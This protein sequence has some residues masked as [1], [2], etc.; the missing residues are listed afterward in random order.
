M[1]ETCPPHP[2]EFRR[3]MVDPVRAGRD[4]T[5]LACECE[6][7]GKTIRNRVAEVD[8]S[9]GRREEKLAAANPSLTTAERDELVR[10][11]CED[12]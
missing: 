12:R 8:R 9:E 6:P 4:P 11:R 7:S 2:T 5:D 10:L 3:Q 1:P